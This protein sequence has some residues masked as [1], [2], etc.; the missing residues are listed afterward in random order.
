M[1]FQLLLSAFITICALNAN[2]QLQPAINPTGTFTSSTGENEENATS[3]QGSAPIK[4]EFKANAENAEGWNAVYEWRFSKE[5]EDSPYLIRYEQDT[6]Y[7]F[8][9]A[10]AHR[11]VLYA[12]FTKGDETIEYTKEYWDENAP[13][14]VSISEDRKSVV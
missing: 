6:E 1:K 11:I 13:I 2:A 12:T 4:G 8:T 5:G 10:G 7:I 9:D 14:T 3:F